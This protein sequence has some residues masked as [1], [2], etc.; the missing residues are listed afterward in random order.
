MNPP[1]TPV[2]ITATIRNPAALRA[3]IEHTM[4]ACFSEDARRDFAAILAALERAEPIEER[5]Q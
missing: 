4:A 3:W 5:Q 1:Q 2:V